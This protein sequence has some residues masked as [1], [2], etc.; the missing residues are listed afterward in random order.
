MSADLQKKLWSLNSGK[1]LCKLIKE[2]EEGDFM[3][4]NLKYI[5]N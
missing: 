5:I 1:F 4:K 3:F 2:N